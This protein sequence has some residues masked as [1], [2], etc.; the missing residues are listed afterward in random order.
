MSKEVKKN[1]KSKDALAYLK[2]LKWIGIFGIFF[3][4]VLITYDIVK[5]SDWMSIVSLIVDF[6]L[7]AFSIYFIV[8]SVKLTKIE[9]NAIE[10]NK[11]NIKTK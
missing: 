11:S 7:L 3:S 2:R 5:Y 8:K 1:V 6:V 10:K 9:K 4:V